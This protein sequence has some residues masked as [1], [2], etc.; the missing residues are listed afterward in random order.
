MEHEPTD[1]ERFFEELQAAAPPPSRPN[2][3][4]NTSSNRKLRTESILPIV[5]LVIS[6]LA[7][8]IAIFLLVRDISPGK[9]A[10]LEPSGYAIVRGFAPIPSDHLVLPLEWQNSGGKS[11]LVRNPHLILREL[12]SDDE[13]TGTS[14]RFTMEGE[15]PEIS[16]K[17]FSGP[18]SIA[19][20]FILDPHSLSLKVQIFHIENWWD[21]EGNLY[22]FRF[23][24]GE[25][26]RV[27][28][29]FEKNLTPQSEEALFDL[30]I[31]EGAGKLVFRGEGDRWGFWPVEEEEE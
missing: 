11:V 14:Y 1:T 2:T 15:F 17:A 10:P 27:Y 28:V 21:E 23:K 20:S 30:Q 12:D 8:C 9:V 19:R 31:P 4:P 18:H 7:L 29:G 5:A 3:R 16:S 13:E 25:R 6:I 26:Y 24:S 22:D